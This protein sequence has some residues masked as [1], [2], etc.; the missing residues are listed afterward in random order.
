VRWHQPHD[1]D[2]GA[3]AQVGGYR[4]GDDEH[5]F[6]ADLVLDY[7]LR[8]WRWNRDWRWRFGARFQRFQAC[9]QRS[10]LV[11]QGFDDFVGFHHF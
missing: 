2:V 11:L 3:F 6:F 9:F 4:G 7:G 5:G 8:G 10:D 1:P